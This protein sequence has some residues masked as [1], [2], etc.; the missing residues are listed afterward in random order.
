MVARFT[1][2]VIMQIMQLEC[3]ECVH[4]WIRTEKDQKPN[5]TPSVAI[6]KAQE[7]RL[8]PSDISEM[9]NN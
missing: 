7:V 5:W 2:V 9:R 3:A 8:L 4:I 1:S 6:F